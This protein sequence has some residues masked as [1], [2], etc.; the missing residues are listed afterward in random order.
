LLLFPGQK[1]ASAG[2]CTISAIPGDC[3]KGARI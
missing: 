2:N 3:R 1:C